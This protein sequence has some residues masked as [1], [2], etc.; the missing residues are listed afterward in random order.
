MTRK[1]EIKTKDSI[2]K[3]ATTSKKHNH[4]NKSYICQ[5]EMEYRCRDWKMEV[6]RCYA[7][8]LLACIIKQWSV[9]QNFEIKR[10]LIEETKYYASKKRF[11][12]ILSQSWTM[13]VKRKTVNKTN[14]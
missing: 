13:N 8:S 1:C 2:K 7:E 4:H 6:L 10:K 11:Q 5:V 3:I 14:P 12:F 9:K